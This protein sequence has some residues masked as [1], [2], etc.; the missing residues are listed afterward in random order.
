M[1]EKTLKIITGVLAVFTAASFLIL[2]APAPE[3]Q[4]TT[5]ENESYGKFVDIETYNGDIGLAYVKSVEEG[6]VFA[7]KNKGSWDR[8]VVDS[9]TGSG[10]YVDMKT[11]NEKPYLAYQ[12]GTLGGER[13]RYAYRNGSWETETV[14]NVSN[15]GVSVGM[16]PSINFRNDR[17]VILYHSPSQGLKLAEK[18]MDW[19]TEI[20]EDEQGWYTDSYSCN[21]TVNA[22]YRARN[23]SSLMKGT[24]DGDWS[25]EDTGRDIRSDLAVA[26]SNCKPHLLY[27]DAETSWITYSSEDKEKKFSQAFFSR[28]SITYREKPHILFHEPGTGLLHSTKKNGSWNTEVIDNSTDTGRYNDI[29]VDQAGNVHTAYTDGKNLTYTYLNTGEIEQQST[30]NRY[31]RIILGFLLAVSALITV[32]SSS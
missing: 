11:R 28:M 13:L 16:Y 21:N 32:A 17:P 10:M 8:E 1:K 7:E 14:D 30:R 3:W 29:A 2:E 25:S 31:I 12:D 22:Y 18:N 15:G 19:E 4:K 20:L 23:R 5:L 27:L 26:E 9:R 6:L 24:Y